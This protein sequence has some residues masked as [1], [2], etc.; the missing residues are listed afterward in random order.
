VGEVCI[1]GDCV[2]IG[3]WNRPDETEKALRYGWLH[4]GDMGYLD[5]D[6]FL[7]I[8][9]RLKDMI[10]TGGEN[11]FCAEVEDAIYSYPHVSECAVIGVP[12][13]KWGERVHAIVRV[14]EGR[15]ATERELI[16]HCRS[17]IAGYK[18]PKSIEFRR[19]PMPLSAIGKI[20][21][22]ELRAPYWEANKHSVTSNG[23]PSTGHPP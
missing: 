3:Y 16:E 5:E 18:C 21:K 6:G 17:R 7:F 19:E 23:N 11:V 8:V 15:G 1:R 12:D 13:A 22:N 2:M 4:S 14:V 20:R 10:V 9:D